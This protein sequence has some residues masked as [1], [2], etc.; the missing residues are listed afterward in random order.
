MLIFSGVSA[1]MHLLTI[2]WAFTLLWKTFLFRFGLISRL[3]RREFPILY[4]IPLHFIVFAAE[5][6]YR[7]VSESNFDSFLT[8]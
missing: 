2:F 5:K 6:A 8:I 1:L 3:F 7:I 4:F